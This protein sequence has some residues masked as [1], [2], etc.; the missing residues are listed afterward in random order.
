MIFDFVFVLFLAQEYC[1]NLDIRNVTKTS[2]VFVNMLHYAFASITMG[3]FYRITYFGLFSIVCFWQYPVETLAIW[4]ISMRLAICPDIH[5]NP[6]PT[7]SNNFAGFFYH[8]V[9]GT[10]TPSVKVISFV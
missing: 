8:F 10:L 6:A 3:A 7:Q 1:N 5:P 9:T 4:I 2:V